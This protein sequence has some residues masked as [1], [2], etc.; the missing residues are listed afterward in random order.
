MDLSLVRKKISRSELPRDDW[1]RT[2]MMIGGFH[3][4]AA[5]DTPTTSV[6]L[7]VECHHGGT[8]VV[9]HPDCY[10]MWEEARQ[11]ER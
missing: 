8:R 1:D 6:D 5:C 9:L 4:C 11:P 2:R 3:F 10:V 7:A